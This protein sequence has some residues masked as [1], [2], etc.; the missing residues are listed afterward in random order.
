MQMWQA[1][2]PQLVHAALQL[3]HAAL[4]AFAEDT[5]TVLSKAA[6]L[7]PSGGTRSISVGSSQGQEEAKSNEEA[8]GRELAYAGAPARLS[9]SSEDEQAAPDSATQRIQAKPEPATSGTRRISRD[10][11]AEKTDQAATQ[12]AMDE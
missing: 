8:E 1:K 12:A 9:S 4:Q 2:N 7:V 10:S 3:D 6:A 5:G 11:S